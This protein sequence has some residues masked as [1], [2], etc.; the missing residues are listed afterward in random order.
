MDDGQ[1]SIPGL[2]HSLSLGGEWI[3]TP[4]SVGIQLA[5][6][7]ETTRKGKAAGPPEEQIGLF[8]NGNAVAL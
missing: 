2:D 5:R 7:N 6:R 4:G 3:K 1:V 8:G